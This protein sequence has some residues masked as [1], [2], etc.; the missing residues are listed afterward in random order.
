MTGSL[1]IFASVRHVENAN[2]G[3]DTHSRHQHT[4]TMLYADGPSRPLR[5]RPWTVLDNL[6][7]H[8]KQGSGFESP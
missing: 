8:C 7:V 4:W 5:A 3:D 2:P 1:I 6:A